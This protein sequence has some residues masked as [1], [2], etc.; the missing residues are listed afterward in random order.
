[1]RKFISTIL[2]VIL[3]VSCICV[4]SAYAETEEL[5]TNGDFEEGEYAPFQKYGHASVIEVSE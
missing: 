2:S 3:A 4:L 1:M 5:L